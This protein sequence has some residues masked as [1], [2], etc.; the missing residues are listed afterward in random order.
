MFLT[1][2]LYASSSALD[3][4]YL[5]PTCF[6]SSLAALVLISS[7]PGLSRDT[8]LLLSG[9]SVSLAHSRIRSSLPTSSIQP[10]FSCVPILRLSLPRVYTVRSLVLLLL[11]FLYSSSSFLLPPTAGRVF[12]STDRP[13][14]GFHT[15]F[16][17]PLS[18]ISISPIPSSTSC[19]C[20]LLPSLFPFR[21]SPQDHTRLHAYWSP[22]PHPP[23]ACSIHFS[24]LRASCH[25][26]NSPPSTGR[27]STVF[28]N[29]CFALPL[30]LPWH[31]YRS[32][33]PSLLCLRRRFRPPFLIFS[34]LSVDLPP[35]SARLC[36]SSRKI[37]R[38]ESSL[39]SSIHGRLS[40]IKH[41]SRTQKGI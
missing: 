32:A 15:L 18:L 12:S 11:L 1:F 27:H 13:H 20:S 31:S 37:P 9:F 38:Y 30:F 21:H 14:P 24:A 22:A 34:L 16:S 26:F 3:A 28:P 7:S 33:L 8:L 19:S 4:A 36:R 5:V 25:N 10:F 23:F 40:L 17:D 35:G 6:P 41:E 2:P 39:F 29:S